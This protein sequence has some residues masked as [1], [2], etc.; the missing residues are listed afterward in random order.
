MR[1]LNIEKAIE[2]K[3]NSME[4]ITLNQEEIQ[5]VKTLNALNELLGHTFD[6]ELGTE[7]MSYYDNLQNTLYLK[8]R[9]KINKLNS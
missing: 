5:I 9:D 3:N 6:E 2:N 1:N 7:T 4:T 8:L